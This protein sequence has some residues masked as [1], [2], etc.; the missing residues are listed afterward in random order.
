MRS[1]LTDIA[2]S[3]LC[4]SVVDLIYLWQFRRFILFLYWV[5][6]IF[7]GFRS[8]LLNGFWLSVT[9]PCSSM[10]TCDLSRS[11]AVCIYVLPVP[12][13]T[14]QQISANHTECSAC[15]KTGGRCFAMNQQNSGAVGCLCPHD[16]APGISNRPIG[17]DESHGIPS[18]TG[19]DVGT[20]SC[21]ESL[22]KLE[23]REIGHPS[24]INCTYTHIKP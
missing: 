20:D 9:V 10:C 23:S 18:F 1:R 22:G 6:F 16:R 21:T 12:L 7:S 24:F 5:C 14:V 13:H 2:I 8:V 19:S 4:N 17:S 3:K 11:L 15:I